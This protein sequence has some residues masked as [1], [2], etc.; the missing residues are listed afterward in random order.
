MKPM[1]Q[2]D[3]WGNKYAT[4]YEY[5]FLWGYVIFTYEF[6]THCVKRPWLPCIMKQ[7]GGDHVFH[8]SF[9]WFRRSISFRV[10]QL[11]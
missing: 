8:W 6:A 11:D 2:C 7:W 10:W 3:R 1:F 5:L 4:A 9:S